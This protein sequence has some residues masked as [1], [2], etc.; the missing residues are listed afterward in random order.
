MFCPKCQVRKLD[1]GINFDR[2]FLYIIN[3]KNKFLSISLQLFL[4]YNK[5]NFLVRTAQHSVR[6]NSIQT[7]Q[8]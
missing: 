3:I 5:L 6:F 2:E 7:G 4:C 1:A 8:S